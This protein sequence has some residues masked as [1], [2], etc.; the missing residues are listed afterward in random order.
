MSTLTESRPRAKTDTG[1]EELAEGDSVEVL[2]AEAA[3]DRVLDAEA[4]AISTSL[5][6]LEAFAPGTGGIARYWAEFLGWS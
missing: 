1:A 5:N 4:Q 6:L 2:A 3:V